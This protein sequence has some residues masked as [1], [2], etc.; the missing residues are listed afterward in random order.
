[1]AAAA[2]SV[3]HTGDTARLLLPASPE[4]IATVAALSVAETACC[5]QTRFLMEVTAS[6]VTLTVQA[7]GSAGLLDT[8][9]PASTP[10]SQ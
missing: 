7:P 9:L 4:L 2:T 8:L 1:M 5:T 10:T 6:Q 3:E